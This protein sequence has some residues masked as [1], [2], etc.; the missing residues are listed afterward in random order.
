MRTQIF[1]FYYWGIIL[2]GL[3]WFFSP[4][5]F[6]FTHIKSSAY[7]DQMEKKNKVYLVGCEVK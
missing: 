3:G 1:L 2:L 5:L 6:G 7:L 4:S